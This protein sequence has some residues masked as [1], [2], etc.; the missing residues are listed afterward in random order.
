MVLIHDDDLER[1]DGIG[2]ANVSRLLIS[3]YILISSVSCCQL[4]E[5]F[6]SDVLMDLLRRSDIE[7][8]KVDCS[9]FSPL[10]EC[11]RLQFL[12]GP[13]Q[14]DLSPSN[15]HSNTDTDVVRWLC[16]Q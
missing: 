8:S 16:S 10:K 6:R 2:D 15:G 13:P 11:R 1:I 7:M 3:F 5:S 9:K 4:M 14:I 12:R